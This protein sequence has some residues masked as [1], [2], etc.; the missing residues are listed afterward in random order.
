[1]LRRLW[2]FDW[3][4]AE[5]NSRVYILRLWIIINIDSDSGTP[6]VMIS[7]SNWA[8]RQISINFNLQIDCEPAT[9]WFDNAIQSYSNWLDYNQYICSYLCREQEHFKGPSFQ[10]ISAVGA[11]AAIVHYSPSVQ[12]DVPITRQEIYLVDSGGQY[13]DGTTDITRTIHLGEPKPAEIDAFTRVLKGSILLGTAVFPPHAPVD[14]LRFTTRN[15]FR[16]DKITLLISLFSSPTS[17]QW[18]DV[19]CGTL[20]WAMDMGLGMVSGPI[21]MFTNIR[22]C[23][24]A[25]AANTAWLR[26]CFHRMVNHKYSPT[27][28][29]HFH[30]VLCGIF[31]EKVINCVL[32]HSFL[33]EPGYYEEKEFG[34]RIE[35]VVQVVFAPKTKHDF[36]GRGAL[37]L[38]DIT[39]VPIQR[40]L[41]DLNMLNKREVSNTMPQYC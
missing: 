35:N 31:S 23:W 25:A 24:V 14:Q 9:N 1:M 15:I 21:S 26:T 30:S 20:V 17:M 38:F 27:V 41:I 10:T 12:T 39:M 8:Y 36:N 28:F 16:P 6:P 11:H 5:H 13:L 7:F 19:I 33:S 18:R 22:R 40:K 2:V 32:I 29:Y 37:K 3:H 34:I 4:F